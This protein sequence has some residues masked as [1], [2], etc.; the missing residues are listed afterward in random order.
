M[1]RE[2]VRSLKR[3]AV[4]LIAS[5]VA[6]VGPAASPAQAVTG[7]FT[8]Y[9]PYVSGGNIVALGTWSGATSELKKVCVGIWIT[10][11]RIPTGPLKTVCKTSINPQG[12]GI[13]V[14]IPCFYA[15][16][17]YT[18]AKYYN[19]AGGVLASRTSS[20]RFITSCTP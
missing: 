20:I 16:G 9:T 6:L 3:I 8:A 11:P 15:A 4:L 2:R 12:G 19:G 5:A 14:E 13:S 10:S 17:Y 7:I 18:V 1:R